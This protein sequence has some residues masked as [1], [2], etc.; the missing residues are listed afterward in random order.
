MQMNT[1]NTYKK[2]DL[3]QNVPEGLTDKQEKG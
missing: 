2:N 1:K 3:R